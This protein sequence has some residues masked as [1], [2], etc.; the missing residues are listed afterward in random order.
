M[1]KE[2]LRINHLKKVYHDIE[3][4]VSAIKDVSLPIYE[5]EIVVLVGPSGCGKSTILSILAGLEDKSS[6]DVL[7]KLDNIRLGYMLQKD[8]LF[9]WLTILDNCLIGLKIQKKLT[10]EVKERVVNLL[11]SYGLKDFKD[12]YPSSLSGGMRQRAALIRT[13]A[14]DPD[15]LL[16]DEAFS[17]L[18]YQTRLILSNDVFNIIKSENKTAILVSHDLA[19]AIS[20]GDRIVVLTSRP[21]EIK[22]VYDVNLTNKSN[23]IENRKCPEFSMYYESIWRDLD[24]HL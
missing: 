16:M 1:K 20:M 19:E 2:L 12:K 13:L 10:T 4:E 11:D 24:A 6:G 15:L 14:V 21:C 17:A 8:A 7:Y 5:G 3:H 22:K 23:P 18:D 9:P